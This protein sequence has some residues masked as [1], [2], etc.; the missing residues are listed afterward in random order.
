MA[1]RQQ[2]ARVGLVNSDQ[3]AWTRK[4][5]ERMGEATIGRIRRFLEHGRRRQA[6]VG[7]QRSVQ[8]GQFAL[9]TGLQLRLQYLC[10]VSVYLVPCLQ[11][12]R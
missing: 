10:T 1:L 4:L 5:G 12:T 8:E 7:L 6:L 9:Q 11:I 2:Q 3:V